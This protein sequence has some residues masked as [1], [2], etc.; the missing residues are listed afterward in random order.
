MTRPTIKVLYVATLTI[1]AVCTCVVAYYAFWRSGIGPWGLYL[2]V[3]LGC[4]AI[5]RK[6]RALRKQLD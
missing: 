3:A 6:L 4:G 5:L 2:L 1:W